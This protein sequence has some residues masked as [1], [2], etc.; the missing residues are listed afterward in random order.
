MSN[1]MT[2]LREVLFQ[3]IKGVRDGSIEIDKAKT[4]SGLAK[5]LIDTAK[6]EVD[7]L[8]ATGSTE[9]SG[10][11]PQLS[12]PG[13]DKP[14]ITQTQTGTKIVQGSSTVHKMK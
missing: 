6:V 4:I 2:E 14:Q 13:S 3:T 5:N 1:D 12:R 8:N 9:G 7:Y 10:F 11:I